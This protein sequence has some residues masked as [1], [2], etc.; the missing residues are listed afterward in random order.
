MPVPCSIVTSSQ[1]I[2]LCSIPE[3]AEIVERAPVPQPD[4]FVAAQSD[5]ALMGSAPAHD[6]KPNRHHVQHFV[7]KHHAFESTRRRGQPLDLSIPEQRALACREI[8]RELDDRIALQRDAAHRQRL[9]QV[10]GEHAGSGA[11]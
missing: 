2:T 4:E 6:E 9:E 3:A 1:G 5:A 7:G 8:G 11:A 10:A